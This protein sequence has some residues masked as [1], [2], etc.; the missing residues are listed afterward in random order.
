M[1]FLGRW[2]STQRSSSVDAHIIHVDSILGRTGEISIDGLQRVGRNI[3]VVIQ[4]KKT[5]QYRHS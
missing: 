4:H 3:I 2:L 5:N 1:H